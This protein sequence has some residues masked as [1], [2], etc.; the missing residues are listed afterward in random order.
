MKRDRG[1]LFQSLLSLVLIALAGLVGIGL[2][3]SGRL[4]QQTKEP[5]EVSRNLILTDHAEWNE[6][7]D[8]VVGF[9]RT[10]ETVAPADAVPEN[11]EAGNV[12]NF[13]TTTRM[14]RDQAPSPSTAPAATTTSPV[15]PHSA[16][17]E[18]SAKTDAPPPQ[19]AAAPDRPQEMGGATK[20]SWDQERPKSP[21]S[22][23]ASE[24]AP[25]AVA[26]PLATAPITGFHANADK[27]K[28][29]M[30]PPV[31]PLASTRRAKVAAPVSAAY[32][33]RVKQAASE[34]EQEPARSR[35]SIPSRTR[36]ALP[37][38]RYAPPSEGPH[39]DPTQRVDPQHISR[40]HQ[41]GALS[42]APSQYDAQPPDGPQFG[43]YFPYGSRPPTAQR[44]RRQEDRSRQPFAPSNDA[45]Q[46][47]PRQMEPRQPAQ[48]FNNPYDWR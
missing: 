30:T 10:A 46:F 2:L 4:W 11:R 22:V 18:L 6:F 23:A 3:A 42:Y 25:P 38:Q 19:T 5:L 40:P 13:L 45:Q 41:A 44:S 26:D 47:A 36:V 33:A 37:K 43:P 15:A 31:A 29:R 35:P 20:P 39:W 7:Y 48:S 34:L 9:G 21:T 14:S 1:L 32:V 27:S 12:V 8:A 16:S 17:S 24:R 28:Q